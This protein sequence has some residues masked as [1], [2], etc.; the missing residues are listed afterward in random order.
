M[1]HLC[2]VFSRKCREIRTTLVTDTEM[3]S[4]AW[5]ERNREETYHFIWNKLLLSGKGV[6]GA[7]ILQALFLRLFHY[8]QMDLVMPQ[9]I[10][11]QRPDTS[12]LTSAVFVG[13]LPFPSSHSPE[14]QCFPFFVQCLV[15]IFR[16]GQKSVLFSLRA[17]LIKLSKL[18]FF[19][20]L[21]KNS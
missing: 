20:L 8:S 14:C 7:N 9:C 11:C 12:I 15:G 16:L 6:Y 10:F 2:L 5:H 4:S 17:Q 19:C 1:S 3:H 21:K 13:K 18:V